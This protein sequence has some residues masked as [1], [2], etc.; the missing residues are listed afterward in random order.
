MELKLERT[1]TGLTETFGELYID[2]EYF[3]DALQ[4]GETITGGTYNILF[5]YYMD[6]SKIYPIL[7]D[8]P[9][10]VQTIHYGDNYFTNQ[11]G[12]ILVGEKSG[13]TMTNCETVWNSLYS[14]ISGL[15]N[16]IQIV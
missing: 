11:N 13:S 4:S 12:N 10:G 14:Q 15:T 9:Y 5:S 7:I 2:D 1:E 6:L 16:T 8:T 3:C